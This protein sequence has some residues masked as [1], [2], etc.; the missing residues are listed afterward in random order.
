MENWID[1]LLET[2]DK[3]YVLIEKKDSPKNTCEL[4]KQKQHLFLTNYLTIKGHHVCFI[5]NLKWMSK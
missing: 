2:E 1:K 5:S 4:V 3:N